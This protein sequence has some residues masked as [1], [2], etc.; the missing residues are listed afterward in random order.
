[1]RFLF[2]II[3]VLLWEFVNDAD[4]A[5][6]QINADTSIESKEEPDTISDNL[7]TAL[8]NFNFDIQKIKVQPLPY[9]I[10]WL[11]RNYVG[12]DSINIIGH[13]YDFHVNLECLLPISGK[14][15]DF[16]VGNGIIDSITACFPINSGYGVRKK[17]RILNDSITLI[18]RLPPI[19]DSIECLLFRTKK[20]GSYFLIIMTYD[21]QLK[22]IIDRRIISI[23]GWGNDNYAFFTA[24]RIEKRHTI[25]II[26]H[27]P[28]ETWQDIVKRDIKVF[29]D[30]SMSVIYFEQIFDTKL[31]F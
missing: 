28:Y 5:L 26:G 7:E 21:K 27:I 8:V 17:L 1:M 23:V 15:N 24:V 22:K 14:L 13:L 9:S 31:T 10:G 16:F 11:Y 12:N 4:V 18:K 29:K 20:M 2:I 3:S 30:G 19:S 6:E 25:K